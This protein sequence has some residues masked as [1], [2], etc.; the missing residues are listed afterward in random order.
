LAQLSPVQVSVKGIS[1]MMRML[2]VLL[3]CL[4]L[5][6]AANA[7][8]DGDST[9]QPG[10]SESAKAEHLKKSMV[11]QYKKGKYDEALKLAKQVLEI[12]GKVDGENSP[13]YASVL[14]DIAVLYEKVVKYDNALT[15]YTR[16]LSGFEKLSG[17]DSPESLR[18]LYRLAGLYLSKRDYGKAEP[19][20]MRAIAIKEKASGLSDL[21]SAEM[22]LQ[23][24]CAMRQNKKE[25]E[26]ALIET[27]V[28]SL[29][30]KESADQPEAITLPG[31]CSTAVRSEL[32]RPVYPER[33]KRELVNGQVTVE[34]II[35]EMGNVISARAVNGHY[36]LQDECVRVAYKA[37]FKPTMVGGKPVKVRAIITYTF[38]ASILGPRI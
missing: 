23:Y 29:T 10:N 9:R 4:V 15:F 18:P 14:F 34:I 27:R 12:T 17:I 36:L 32:P 6:G 30:L 28:S 16:A 19:L 37:K 13:S 25:T 26:A 33:A 22:L 5:P 11:E 24:A 1:L 7:Q 3:M 31:E 38:T 35:D 21:S 2:A 20:Y 8:T